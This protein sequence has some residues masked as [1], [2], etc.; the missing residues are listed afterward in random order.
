MTWPQWLLAIGFVLC[1]GGVMVAT[2][3]QGSPAGRYV[4]VSGLVPIAIGGLG[5]LVQRLRTRQQR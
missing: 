2:V 5:A 1:I 4:M 3:T